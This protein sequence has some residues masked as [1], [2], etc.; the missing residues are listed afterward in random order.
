MQIEFITV[1][2]NNEQEFIKNLQ[3]SFAVKVH[4]EFGNTKDHL[5]PTTEDI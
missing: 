2:K 1:D 4:R 3:E 5:I